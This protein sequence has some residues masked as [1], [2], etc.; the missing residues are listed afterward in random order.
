MVLYTVVKLMISLIQKTELC[1]R[2]KTN[3]YLTV[4]CG[5]VVV[6]VKWLRQNRSRHCEV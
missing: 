5:D 4:R 3:S 2:T 6:V 1:R